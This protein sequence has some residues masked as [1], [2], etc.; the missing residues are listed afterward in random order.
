MRMLNWQNFFGDNTANGISAYAKTRGATRGGTMKLI[1]RMAQASPAKFGLA[2]SVIAGTA[3][4]AQSLYNQL[5]GNSSMDRYRRENY[6][7]FNP[8]YTSEE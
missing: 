4:G 5:S 3:Q 8:T 1:Q 2:G 6:T 7:P